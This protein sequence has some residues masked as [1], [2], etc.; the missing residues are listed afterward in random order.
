[1]SYE[2]RSVLMRGVVLAAAAVI[3]SSVLAD[4]DLDSRMADA[5]NW[6][7]QAGD[8]ANHRH[9][10]LKQINGSNVS[11]LQVAWTMSTGVLRGHEGSPLVIGDTDRKS[12]V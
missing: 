11:Q 5:S 7:S 1:M 6:A 10:T 12:V 3:S 4:T 2:Y 9:T 8:N